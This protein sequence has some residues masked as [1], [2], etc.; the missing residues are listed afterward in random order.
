MAC[1]KMTL[2]FLGAGTPSLDEMI[3]KGVSM[4]G[5]GPSGWI[6][7][8][9]AELAQ[10]FGKT[11]EPTE[12]RSSDEAESETLLNKGI[13]TLVR[14]LAEGAPAPVSVVKEFK[15]ADKYHM[16]LLVGAETSRG[17]L[18]GFYYHD[19]AAN[20]ADEGKGKFVDIDTFKKYWRR[21]ALIVK[22]Q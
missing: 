14:S 7:K 8:P 1:L 6:H 16:V 15:Y 17:A 18:E 10:T 11:I 20:S 3:Q 4:D 22:P 13:I 12:F 9:L 5:Y 2:D 19:P 21:M